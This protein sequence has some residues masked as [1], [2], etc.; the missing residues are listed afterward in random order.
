MPVQPDDLTAKARIREAALE[1]FAANGVAGTSLRS[2]AARAGVSPSLVVHHF[3]TKA[4]L[5]AAVDDAVV[6]SF[7][8]ALASTDLSGSPDAVTEHVEQALSGIIGGDDPTRSYLAR[9]LFEGGEAS[10]RLFDALLDLLD[11]GLAQ[12]DAAGHLRPGTDPTWR[13]YTAAFVI[14]GPVLLGR[15]IGAR[16]HTDPFDPALVQARSAS[17]RA[18]LQHGLFRSTSPSSRRR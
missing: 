17:S 9:S 14:L 1:L 16:L 12:L 11:D 4:R 8:D 6:G 2:V 7:A 13:A 5:R 10:Q 3:G 15:Q 18:V